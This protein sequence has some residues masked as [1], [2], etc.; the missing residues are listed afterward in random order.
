[1]ISALRGAGVPINT[2]VIGVAASMAAVISQIGDRKE[3]DSDAMFNLHFASAG[4]QGRGTAEDHKQAIDLLDGINDIILS[5]LKGSNLRKR[6]LV[7]LMNE[8]RL[9]DSKEAISLG[10]FDRA[11]EPLKAVALLTNKNMTRDD[12]KKVLNEASVRLGFTDP[13][14]DEQAELIAEL[15]EKA[16]A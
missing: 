3:I 11:T 2:R 6:D 12:F 5:K 8:D 14:D 15:A 9:M 13:K 7:K 4:T 16:E 1:M 10:F